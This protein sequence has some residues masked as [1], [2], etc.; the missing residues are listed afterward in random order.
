MHLAGPPDQP[1]SSV[2]F[3]LQVLYLLYFSF[4]APVTDLLKPLRA[5]S[6][7]KKRFITQ[8]QAPVYGD[9]WR[10]KKLNC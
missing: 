7:T 6:G 1:K 4:P 8:L 10:V 3:L 5:I 9:V 2:Q